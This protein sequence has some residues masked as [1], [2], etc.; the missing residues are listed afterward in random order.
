MLKD[1]LLSTLIADTQSDNEPARQ[2]LAKM[3]LIEECP[4]VYLSCAIGSAT[5][6]V[7]NV[8]SSSPI[9]TS[10]RVHKR[11]RSDRDHTSGRASSAPKDDNSEE[12]QEEVSSSPPVTTNTPNKEKEKELEQMIAIPAGGISDTL[13]VHVTFSVKAKNAKKS[14]SIVVKNMTVDDLYAVY[15]LGEVVFDKKFANLY[16]YV[17]C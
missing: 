10:R 5:N 17:A 1:T 4:H 14:T 11:R 12:D 6:N 9:S 8:R 13:E 15:K 7:E 3:G 2:F 16:R